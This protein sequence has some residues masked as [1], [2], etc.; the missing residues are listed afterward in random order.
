[1]T[2]QIRNRLNKIETA[3]AGMEPERPRRHLTAQ[4]QIE[5][6]T[7]TREVPNGYWPDLPF[8]KRT[9][10]KEL[11]FI[12]SYGYTV[13]ELYRMPMKICGG[14]AKALEAARQ[15]RDLLS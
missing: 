8:E 11:H 14:F 6:D 15:R 9:R 2:V 10:W 4:E 7:L 1:M 5:L 3:L 13:A 12:R